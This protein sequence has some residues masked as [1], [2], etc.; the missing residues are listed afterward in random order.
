MKGAGKVRVFFLFSLY[1]QERGY[2]ESGSDGHN[3]VDWWAGHLDSKEKRG[4]FMNFPIH[5]PLAASKVR[6]F[7]RSD[8]NR[9]SA[10]EATLSELST[11]GLFTQLSKKGFLLNKF[12]FIRGWWTSGSAPSTL[13]SIHMARDNLAVILWAKGVKLLTDV[14]SLPLKLMELTNVC[15]TGNGGSKVW[16]D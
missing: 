14:P 5:K 8:F 10:R 15:W 2:E 7:L 4:T 16:L 9:W 13:T 6:D 3:W 12:S 1:F 11:S